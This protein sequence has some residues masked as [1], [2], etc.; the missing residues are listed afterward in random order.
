MTQRRTLWAL[1]LALLAR[2]DARKTVEEFA[3]KW[4]AEQGKNG[5]LAN[6]PLKV[7]FADESPGDP[8][9]LL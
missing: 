4:M 6:A 3:R 2:A 7:R 9:H 8:P 5:S 1:A